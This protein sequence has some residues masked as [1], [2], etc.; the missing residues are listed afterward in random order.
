LEGF[1]P[2]GFFMNISNI[3]AAGAVAGDYASAF[4]SGTISVTKTA[5]GATITTQRG[6]QGDII[7]VTTAAPATPRNAAQQA[8]LPQANEWTVNITA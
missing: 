8:E 3:D 1:H 6:N 4:G 2:G 5:N 7:A